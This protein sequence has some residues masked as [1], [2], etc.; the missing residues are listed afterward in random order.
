MPLLSIKEATKRLNCDNRTLRRW[1]ERGTVNATQ[2]VNGRLAIEE[3]E[4]ERVAELLHLDARTHAPDPAGDTGM[5]EMR[6]RVAELERE[7]K[8][9]AAHVHALEQTQKEPMNSP[10]GLTIPAPSQTPL[11]TGM[12]SDF[13]PIPPGHVSFYKFAHGMSDGSA[14]RWKKEQPDNLAL[15]GLW[16][17][18]GGHTIRVLLSPAGQRAYYLWAKDRNGFVRCDLCPHEE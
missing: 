2:Q 5:A 18:E 13:K 7:M 6:E 8:R 11:K 15:S 12:G 17:D 10:V 14:G 16:N 1:I 3:S 4:V 9:L